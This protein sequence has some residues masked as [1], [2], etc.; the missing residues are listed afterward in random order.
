MKHITYAEKSVVTG[1]DVADALVEYAK[2]VAQHHTADFV[3]ISGI[4][5][6]GDEIEATFL[7]GPGTNMMIETA[8]TSMPEPDNHEV[9]EEIRRKTRHLVSP[10]DAGGGTDDEPIA[11]AID[12]W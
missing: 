11:Q 12:E 2:A 10:P 1:D 7:L 4:G 8:H 9:T 5:S 3:T 6:N